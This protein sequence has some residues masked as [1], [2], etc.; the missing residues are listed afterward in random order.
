VGLLLWPAR[1]VPFV[2]YKQALSADGI[3]P[4][5]FRGKVVFV[6]ARPMTS[7]FIEKRDELRNPYPALN[8]EFIFMPMVEVHATQFLNLDRGDWLTRPSPWSE[9]LVLALAS[10]IFGFGLLR[11]RPTD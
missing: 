1:T 5:F 2:S 3:A 9:S 6:G 8:K 10:F 4:G 7:S 11:F